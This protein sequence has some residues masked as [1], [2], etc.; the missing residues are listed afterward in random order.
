MVQIAY[1]IKNVKQLA[2]FLL[3]FYL[4]SFTFGGVA[5]A[6]LYF[7]KPE[8][9]FSGNGVFVGVYP[10]GIA[11]FG[12]IVGFV[13]ILIAFKNI[14]AKLTKKDVLC[15]ITITYMGKNKKVV[16]M[17]DT[18]NLLKEPITGNQVIVV[19][20]EELYEVLPEEILSNVEEIINGRSAVK[21]DE[22]LA[23]FRVIPFTSLGKENGLLLGFKPDALK[24]D[25]LSEEKEITD[26]VV[27]IYNGKLSKGASYHALV[28]LEILN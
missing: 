21:Q 22:Y 13:V 23:K 9:I 20:R 14:K 5:L 2:K 7:I 19:E 27:G 16:A 28:G 25:Y 1:S 17:V 15:E 3:I 10:L 24:I 8:N 12:G 18:G 26:G 11:V 6:L 4:T